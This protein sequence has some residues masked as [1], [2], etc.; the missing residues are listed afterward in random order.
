MLPKNINAIKRQ[1]ERA[2][3]ERIQKRENNKHEKRASF[4]DFNSTS[5][6]KPILPKAEY[7]SDGRPIKQ[8]DIDLTNL[9]NEINRWL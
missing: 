7:T 4:K 9:N 8:V 2:E 6:G 5:D 1:A 3:I